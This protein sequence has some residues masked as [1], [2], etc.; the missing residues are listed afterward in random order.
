MIKAISICF[1]AFPSFRC[2]RHR[3]NDIT[4]IVY[5]GSRSYWTTRDFSRVVAELVPA[6]SIVLAPRSNAR[7]CWDKPGDDSGMW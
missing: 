2:T 7:G 4:H 5:S 6:T 3:N 1:I